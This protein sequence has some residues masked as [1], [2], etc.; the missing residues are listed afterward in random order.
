MTAAK[1]RFWRFCR[2]LGV[3]VLLAAVPLGTGCTRKNEFVPPPPPAVTVA[4]PVVKEVEDYLEFT[5]TTRAVDTVEVRAR[6]A[7]YVKSIEFE[8]GQDVKEGDLLYVIEQEPF[9]VALAS[10]EAN[11]AKAE[12]ALTLAEANLR[13]TEPLVKRGAI[14]EQELD[15][16]RADVATA[17]AELAAAKAAVDQAKLNLDYTEV[18]API[19]GRIGRHL[20]DVGNLIAAQTTALA[21]VE[22]YQPIHVYFSVSESDVLR[23]MELQRADASSG[24]M[25]P[26]R[27]LLLGLSEQGGFPYRGQ[28]DYT[29]LG[30]DPDTGTQLRRGIFANENRELV[31]GLFVR[32]RLML[33][34]P[35]PRLLIDE[36]AIAADQRGEYVLTVNDKDLV[37]YRPVELGMRVEGM[38]VVD[39]GIGA[40]D[41]VVVNGI[42]RARPG[43]PVTVDGPGEAH[44]QATGQSSAAPAVAQ[45]NEESGERQTADARA[46]PMQ[47]AKAGG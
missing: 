35:Q 1:H 31:P 41:R 20:V 19:S 5:G 46:N 18:R 2:P 11:L 8:D 45:D 40:D 22:S 24:D 4:K 16:R 28:L 10:A 26:P 38:R 30:I 3:L 37:E 36:R 32:V 23:L 42:Q 7:G 17:R 44:A 9:Q 34:K 21:T 39:R 14:P 33:G 12:A 43:A 27:E 6:V 47:S 29:D 25:P 13:R 15:V